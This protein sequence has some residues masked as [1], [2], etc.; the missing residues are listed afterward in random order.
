MKAREAEVIMSYIYN[1][2]EFDW[3]NFVVTDKNQLTFHHIVERKNGGRALLDN[4]A[5]VTNFAHQLLNIL[6]QYCQKAY[7]DLQEVFIKINE[8]KNPPTLEM[9]QRIDEILYNFFFTDKYKMSIDY[10][11]NNYYNLRK[12]LTRCFEHYLISRKKFV[13][14]LK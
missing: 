9:I 6:D 8:S 2:N 1:T 12:C 14:C 11:L 10:R 5:L 3:M 7:N 4:G 13:K